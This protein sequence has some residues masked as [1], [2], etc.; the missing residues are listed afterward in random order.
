MIS[1]LPVRHRNPR[2]QSQ[3]L[4]LLLSPIHSSV[5]EAAQTDRVLSVQKSI[6]ILQHSQTTLILSLLLPHLYLLLYLTLTRLLNQFS[7]WGQSESLTF[8]PLSTVLWR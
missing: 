5:Q 3:L 8:V 1:G 6:S 7:I 2:S 4:E